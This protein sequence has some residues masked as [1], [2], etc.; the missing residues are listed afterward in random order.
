MDMEKVVLGYDI[1][2]TKLGIGLMT[3]NGKVLGQCRIENK[4]T[5]PEVILPQLVSSSRDL[6]KQAFLHPDRRIF[7]TGSLRLLSITPIGAMYLFCSI[8][9]ITWGSPVVLKMMPTAE[10]LPKDISEPAAM[11]K[12]LFT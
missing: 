9:R 2:G 7:P 5:Y 12:I 1:G 11:W 6:V 3:E 4:D 10:P 8:C